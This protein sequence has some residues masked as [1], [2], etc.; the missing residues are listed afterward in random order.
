MTVPGRIITRKH[1]IEA[2]KNFPPANI[3]DRQHTCQSTAL[4]AGLRV[5]GGKRRSAKFSGV[6]GVTVPGGYV[7]MGGRASLGSRDGLA[8]SGKPPGE[9]A[10]GKQCCR[11]AEQAQQVFPRHEPPCDIRQ[12]GRH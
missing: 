5:A 6:I 4:L 2:R 10:A 8:D 1:G 12:R 7:Q 11:V 9:E 3:G